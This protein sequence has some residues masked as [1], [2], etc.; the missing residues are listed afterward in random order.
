MM[1]GYTYLAS[2]LLAL[3]F[4]PPRLAFSPSSPPPLLSRT[5]EDAMSSAGAALDA[6]V[7]DSIGGTCSEV[8][9]AL[10]AIQ[11]ET[12]DRSPAVRTPALVKEG[13]GKHAHWPIA[14]HSTATHSITVAL[15]IDASPGRLRLKFLDSSV[16]I[17]WRHPP[18]VG[19]IFLEHTEDGCSRFNGMLIAP[20]YR[21]RGLARVLVAI[22]A[23]LALSS[24]LDVS[25]G[26]IDK[27]ILAHVLGSLGFVGNGG[28]PVQLTDATRL[29]DCEVERARRTPGGGVVRVNRELKPTESTPSSVVACL[30]E[31]GGDLEMAA[32]MEVVGLALMDKWRVD[33]RVVI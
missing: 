26:V 27:P 2:L 22:W 10:D 15:A 29:E 7:A 25:T 33:G 4:V 19:T 5:V 13:K 30:E 3:V 14:E 9:A 6:L 8:A 1:V 20:S 11:A 16:P 28:V 31:D 12:F 17:V 24:G 23:S 18:K 21:G 32:S